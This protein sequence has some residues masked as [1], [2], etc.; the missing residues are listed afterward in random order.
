MSQNQTDRSA[1]D[2]IEWCYD[3]VHRVSRTFSLTIAELDEPMARDICV[4]YLLCRVADTIEDA[5][6]VPPGAQAELLRTYSRVLDPASDTTVRA[7]R[8]K[9]DEWL[10]ATRSADWEVVDEAPRVVRVFRQLEGTRRR[11]SAV[12]SANSS[13]AWRCSSTATPTTAASA[14]RP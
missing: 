14:S 9:V 7:F 3:A 10:P 6:H 12:Q 5:G 13:T 2:D 11:P 4:G 1:Q 8:S